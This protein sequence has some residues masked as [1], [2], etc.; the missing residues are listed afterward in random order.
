MSILVFTDGS[1]INNGQKNAKAGYGVYFPNKELNDISEPFTILKITNQRAELFA[2]YKALKEITDKLQFNQ[3]TVYTDSLYSIKCVTLWIKSWEKNNWKTK[4]GKPVLNLDIIKSISE[5]LKKYNSKQITFKH[6]RSH[7]NL[8]N[9]ESI[10][11]DMADKL[12]CAGTNRNN[13]NN[14]NVDNSNNVDKSNI[15]SVEDIE[16]ITP[17]ISNKCIQ[18][19]PIRKRIFVKTS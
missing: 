15:N 6:V 17:T 14:N 12:A 9:Y 1:C 4:N 11:N 7:T 18:N 5:I 2:I 8:T 3:I 19:K 13:N 16:D 10:C